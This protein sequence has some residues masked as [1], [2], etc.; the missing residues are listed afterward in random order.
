LTGRTWPARGKGDHMSKAKP[1]KGGN[2]KGGAVQPKPQGADLPSVSE[3][4]D[5]A[6][7]ID[8][9]HVKIFGTA[10]SKLQYLFLKQSVL[11]Y[12]VKV[13]NKESVSEKLEY[14]YPAIQGIDP[15]D[16]LEGML[17]VQMVGVH[18]VAMECL[19]RAQLEEQTFPG[20][21]ANL[22]YATRLLQVFTAQMEALQRYRGKSTQQTVT[23]E[24]VHVHQGGQAIVGA[25]N[26][27]DKG[28]GGGDE[29]KK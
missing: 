3:G 20:R 18:N 7:T 26:H 24:H 9:P 23:V 2:P 29:S 25:V 19:G 15:Q 8:K 28:G 6:V 5:K 14:I 17:S 13:F 1:G 21:T 16:A 12:G 11:A 22:Q 10:N 4:E 27:Q